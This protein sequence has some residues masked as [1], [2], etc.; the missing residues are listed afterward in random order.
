MSTYMLILR[1]NQ[2]EELGQPQKEMFNRFRDFTVALQKS[3]ALKGFER[4]KPGAEGKTAR[5]HDGA[6]TIEGPYADSNGSAAGSHESV[7]GFY[8]IEAA[9]EAAVHVIAKDCPILRAGGSVEIRET[10]FFPGQ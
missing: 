3:G 4:L 2:A 9:D 7:I 5:N 6:I 8:L 10:E 1:R